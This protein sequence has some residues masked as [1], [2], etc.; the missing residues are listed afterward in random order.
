MNNKDLEKKIK[1]VM[2]SLVFE[3]G[4]VCAV[5]V[6]MKLEY[7]SE[8]DYNDWRFGK[9]EFLEKT[10]NINLGKLSTI[11]IT[12]RKIANEMNLKSSWTG[13][14][15]YGKGIKQRLIFSKSRIKNI[16]DTYATHYL[17]LERI[18]ELKKK[19]KSQPVTRGVANVG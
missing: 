4:Y 2:H 1:S 13:Y 15:R 11:N 18:E 9:I 7:L 12:I 6:L 19:N 14:N 3:K 8:K 5:D 16:E 10:C 17:N